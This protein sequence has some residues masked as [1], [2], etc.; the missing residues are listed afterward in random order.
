MK[1][2]EKVEALSLSL[3]GKDIGVLT[4]YAGGKN[5]LVESTGQRNTLFQYLL[6]G[7]KVKCFSRSFI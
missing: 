2:L 6:W 3:Y 4:H 5:I 1:T 7:F